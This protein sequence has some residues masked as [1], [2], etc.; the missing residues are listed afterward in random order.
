MK[1]SILLIAVLIA[2]ICSAGCVSTPKDIIGTWT[3]EKLIDFPA[4]NV[5]QIVIVF[6]PNGKGT[7]TWVYNDGARY[8]SNMSWIKNED[9]SYAYAYDS[10]ITT[11]SDDG[12]TT[13]DE[14]GRTY[15]RED[16][17]ILGGYV[18]TWITQ[19]E[20][21]YNGILY[22]I[23]DKIYANNTGISLWT[24]HDGR[25]EQPWEIIW[26]PYKENMYINYYKEALIGFT[27]LDNGTGL[28][29]Y[30]LTYTKS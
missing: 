14:E 22:T 18:G 21:E 17:D 7:E 27:I 3:S 26:Y 20:Y 10:W 25:T 28:D 29:N 4:P 11:I 24:T 5:T 12:N 30:D 13:T 1:K 19:K 23:T 6:N 9:G 8:V 2:I 16:G 15:V